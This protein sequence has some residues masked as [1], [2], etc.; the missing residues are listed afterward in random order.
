MK[1]WAER[2]VFWARRK[3]VGEMDMAL[4]KAVDDVDPHLL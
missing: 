1:D 2:F 4:P 3:I